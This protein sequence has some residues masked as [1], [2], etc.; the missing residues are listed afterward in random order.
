M[1]EL[2]PSDVADPLVVRTVAVP[3]VG[4]LADLLP[5]DDPRGAMSWIR[6][7]DGL[8]A[9]G[10]AARTDVAGPDRMARADAWFA[11][12]GRRAVVRDE[13][14][15]R[16]TGAVAFGS[17]SFSP[18]S[19]AG[20]SLVVPRVVIGRRDG[21]S[22]LTTIETG[23]RV[24]PRPSLARERS[25]AAPV[26]EPR[27][28][29]SLAGALEPAAWRR[30]VADVVARIRAGEAAKVVLARDSW[31]SA[32]EPVDVR[33]LL[34]RLAGDYDSC[35]TFAVDGLVGATPE[36]LVRRERGLVASR[37]LAGTIRR[38]GDDDADLARAATLARSSKD[39]EEHEFA[40]SSLAA[41]LA[42]FAATANVPEV[43]SVLHLPNVMHLATDVTAVLDEVGDEAPSSLALAAALHPTAAVCGT[44]TD[45]AARIIAEAEGMDRGR[46]AGPVG[47]LG[48][49]GDG[50]WGIALRCAEVSTD[51]PRRLRLFAGCGIV[52]ASDP[53]AE[54]AESEA[55]LVPVR[56]A[57]GIG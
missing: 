55:K 46:Y 32:D 20:G 51:D 4:P 54:L 23:A 38:T 17:F 33:S 30:A 53:V 42:P 25:A 11:D 14:G 28:V 1:T 19:P 57:L 37:V 56:S 22:W 21:V 43:P 40:V 9:W 24:G 49:D 10:E 13:V 45:V 39:L 26:R 27:G 48:A 5:H 6:R 34:R 18:D 50:E 29:R 12:L 8:V 3:D 44:P 41:A 35:W 15:V 16:G 36:L 47:W 7:G 52:A 31:A 2:A